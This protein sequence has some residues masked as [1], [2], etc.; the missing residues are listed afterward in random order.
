MRG[1]KPTSPQLKILQGQPVR[2]VK[3]RPDM[4]TMPV[5][6]SAG[7]KREWKRLAREL[8]LNNVLTTWDRALFAT[9]C[10]AVSVWQQASRQVAAE[11]LTFRDGRGH[12]R[13]NPAVRIMQAAADQ[14]RLGGEK[15]G[16]DPFSRSRHPGRVPDEIPDIED[17]LGGPPL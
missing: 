3:P 16:L 15:F 17:V 8:F 5:G 11:G 10:E 14:V 2:A 9:Y 7:A 1:R 12:L 6:L 13:P 4:P